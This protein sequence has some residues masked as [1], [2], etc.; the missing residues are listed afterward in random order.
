MASVQ[1]SR[2]TLTEYQEVFA[3]FCMEARTEG[4]DAKITT[5]EFTTVSAKCKARCMVLLHRASRVGR[6]L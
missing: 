5:E 1:I 2:Q 6:R 4:K 3:F